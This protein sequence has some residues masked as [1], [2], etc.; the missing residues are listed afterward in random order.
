[1]EGPR[2]ADGVDGNPRINNLVMV[3]IHRSFLESH[4]GW[5]M[6]GF[7][8]KSLSTLIFWDGHHDALS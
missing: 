2:D 7:T 6:I 8:K 5:F 4:S 3:Y 1:M